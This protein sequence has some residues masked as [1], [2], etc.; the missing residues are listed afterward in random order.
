MAPVEK[1]QRTVSLML[2][3]IVQAFPGAPEAQIAVPV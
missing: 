2:L 3:G 1:A